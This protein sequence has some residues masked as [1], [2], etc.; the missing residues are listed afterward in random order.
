MTTNKLRRIIDKYKLYNIL[1]IAII[2][3]VLLLLAR[4][5][6]PSVAFITPQNINQIIQSSNKYDKTIENFTN[7]SYTYYGNQLTL[8]DPT[9]KPIYRGNTC[10]F[11]F[12][13]M[14]RIEAFTIMFNNNANAHT[15]SNIN[16]FSS[17]NNTNSLPIYIQYLDGNGNLRYIQ[18][19]NNTGGIPNFNSGSAPCFSKYLANCR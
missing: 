14:Y 12:D 3:I 15:G 10:T 7:M 8:Q 16:T 17:T 11:N 13:G 18:S 4:A 19:S 1:Q 5:F 9:N 2:L 6:I